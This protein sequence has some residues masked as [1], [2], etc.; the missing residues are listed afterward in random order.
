M[1]QSKLLLQFRQLQHYF[2]DRND[3]ISSEKYQK[4]I[5][6]SFSVEQIHG[7]KVKVVSDL[8]KSFHLRGVSS[9]TSQVSFGCFAGFDGIVTN[10][11]IFLK[12]KTADC[13]PIFFYEYKKR[14]VG[15]AHAGWR[16]L[17]AGVIVEA[18]LQIEN[19]GG[20]RENIISAVGPHI[21]ACCYEVSFKRV[22]CFREKF[23][24]KN[25]IAKSKNSRWYL[26]LGK[27]AF[28]QMV[29][30]G[31]KKEN[32]DIL[33]VCTSCDGRFFSYRRDGSSCGRMYS[34]VGLV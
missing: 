22:L 12:I 11:P 15:A 33:S 16:G 27:M 18:L 6:N 34:V 30:E 25:Q 24:D 8:T 10:K 26:N 21:R 3:S 19:L 4:L 1:V 14:I 29:K 32:I 28:L 9:H 20:R 2:L 23:A 5:K 7:N 17:L 13:L 31:I